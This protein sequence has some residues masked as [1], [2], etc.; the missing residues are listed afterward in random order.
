MR[1]PKKMKFDETVDTSADSF[2]YEPQLDFALDSVEGA[3]ALNIG[4]WT[5]N[6]ESLAVEHA[7]SIT[8]LDVEPR[9]L[10]VARRAVP[11]AAFVEGSVF[12]LP[13]GDGSFDAV[14]MFEVLEHI[15]VGTE[16]EAFAEIARVLAPGGA[17][18]LTTPSW[19]LR[20]RML[21]PAY[22]VAGH[23]HYRAADVID[24]LRASG[25]ATERTAVRGGWVYV[26]TYLTFYFYKHVLRRAMPHP[27]WLKRAYLRSTLSPG[28]TTMY[29]LARK[30]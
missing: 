8:G 22:L 27:D 7:A 10:E 9:A 15:P 3:R 17:L 2:L 20:S 24:M 1:D 14:T 23:R 12:E 29:V 4:C 6:F 25:L 5:G 30:N 26:A 19:N 18:V 21:D 16:S 28:F 13:F 11:G